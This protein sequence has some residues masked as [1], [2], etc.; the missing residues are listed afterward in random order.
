MLNKLKFFNF[1]KALD[2]SFEIL[3]NS[4]KP[5]IFSNFIV[6]SRSSFL[7]IASKLV[8]KGEITIL[9]I[10]GLFSRPSRLIREGHELKSIFPASP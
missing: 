7:E 1:D 3:V 9:F 2:S 6:I 8:M 4:S 5:S 10:C